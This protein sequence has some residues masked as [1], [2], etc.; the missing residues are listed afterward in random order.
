LRLRQ[1][2]ALRGPGYVY[3][4]AA[5]LLDRYGITPSKAADRVRSCV[6]TLAEYGCRPTLPT[7]GRVVERH[8]QFVRQLQDQGVEIAVHGYDHFDLAAYSASEAQDQL[9]RAAEV[10]ARH[11]IETYGF[12]CPYL[13][14][15][16][17]LLDRLPKGMFEYSSNRAIWWDV[18]PP[19]E[20]S[21]ATTIFD[22]LGRFYKPRSA[23][24]ALSVP[25][26]RPNL[27]EIP[28]CLPD[29]LQIHDG[30]GL[31][32]RGIT[33]AWRRVLY[34]TYQRGE[35]F[36][37]HFH[38]ELAWQC[39]QPFQELLSQAARLQ[40]PVWIA[41]LRDVSSWWREKSTFR[42][43]IS[44]TQAALLVSFT[45]SERATILVRGL[46]ACVAE[47]PW[48]GVYR[49]LD[50]RA[51]RVPAEPRP[52]IGLHASAKA[53]VTSFL[54]EQGYIIDT[55]EAATR[56]ATYVDPATLARLTSEVELINYIEASTGPLIRYGRWPNGAKSAL[57]VT[58]DLDALTLLDYA[59]RLFAA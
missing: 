3:R 48:D 55:G 6:A 15:T 52:F 10:F 58:G 20:A 54:R 59:S 25:S 44:Q 24:E 43:T 38:P 35:L 53:R 41:R 28:V 50:T 18:V 26:E 39:R 57:C 9:E 36:V 7:P 49:Q 34:T 56:C 27:V 11:G 42:A 23:L 47:R 12:R 8:P 31:E 29:D 4:R 22:A 37:L 17:E 13:S 1:W 2:L 40:P 5:I 21:A 33:Q 51:L 46:G 45:C 32:S 16:N 19:F 30:L 14:Y